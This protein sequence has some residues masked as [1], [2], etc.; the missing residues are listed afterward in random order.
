MAKGHDS[1]FDQR[2]APLFYR[3]T[4]AGKLSMGTRERC[5]NVPVRL[6]V[7]VGDYRGSREGGLPQHD[8][9]WGI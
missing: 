3:L 1:I 7:V 8:G 5:F 6:T 9:A 2:R 4:A